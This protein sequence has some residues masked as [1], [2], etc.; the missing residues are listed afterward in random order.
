MITQA[1]STEEDDAP[2]KYS[3]EVEP[4]TH[5]TDDSSIKQIEAKILD[6]NWA[7]IG[8]NTGRLLTTLADTENDDIFAQDQIRVFIDFMW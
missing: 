4:H 2:F 7:F 3:R 8:D 6:F 5:E 1:G